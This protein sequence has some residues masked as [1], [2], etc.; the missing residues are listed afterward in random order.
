MDGDLMLQRWCQSKIRRLGQKPS[1]G[2]SA[3][4]LHWRAVRESCASSDWVIHAAD[5]Y[6]GWAEKQCVYA[7]RFRPDRYAVA[8]LLLSRCQLQGGRHAALI[9]S[10]QTDR[11]VGADSAD[12]CKTVDGCYCGGPPGLPGGSQHQFVTG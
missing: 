1:L 8:R 9:P 12:A 3:L 2:W 4:V 11:S 5:G 10:T 6:T 7:A